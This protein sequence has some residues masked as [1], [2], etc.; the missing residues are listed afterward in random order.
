MGDWYWKSGVVY[1]VM[2]VDFQR[3]LASFRIKLIKQKI[4]IL[5]IESWPCCPIDSDC[6]PYYGTNPLRSSL[7]ANILIPEFRM[8][9]DEPPRE[10]ALRVCMKSSANLVTY[11]YKNHNAC[12]GTVNLPWIH[13]LADQPSPVVI[14][15]VPS[16][17]VTKRE[18]T[19][20]SS[21][22]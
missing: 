4:F 15:I 8:F 20:R 21:E 9:V 6:D 5:N 3:I 22:A 16:K 17:T 1:G 12:R 11:I 18:E 10:A 2:F 14:M 13:L 19:G 7:S